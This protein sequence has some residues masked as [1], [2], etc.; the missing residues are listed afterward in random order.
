MAKILIQSAV[1][2]D[3][4]KVRGN[5]EDS[6]L[7]NG[8]FMSREAMND[9]A[10]ESKSCDEAFQ[11]YAVCDGMGGVEAGEEASYEAVSQLARY[12]DNPALPVQ[13]EDVVQLV[14]EIS[15]K[16][17]AA[18]R[19]R[20]IKSG[21]TLVL[22]LVHDGMAM[23]L[24][25]GD[26]RIYRF[27]N[28]RLT[29]V[30]VDHSEVQKL[31][32]MG[33]ITPEEAKSHPRRHAINQFLGMSRELRMLPHVESDVVLHKNDVYLLC[34][35]GLTDMVSDAGIEQ[36]LRANA[37]PRGAVQELVQAALQN[38]GRDNVTAMV[39]RV[40]EVS[41]VHRKLRGR[42][43]VKRLLTALQI[44][45]AT[46]LLVTLADYIYFLLKL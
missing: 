9:G 10:L 4:G 32:S 3:K 46:G 31:I 2:N 22:A 1:M 7:L 24:N 8:E 17:N 25:V 42:E 27:A 34:S 23:L 35:D 15:S 21:T 5:N 37:E 44:L 16:I 30:S 36:I 39:L 20:K 14:R 41:P 6:Y 12:G 45:V 29:Q 28:G 19:E 38:G 18:A 11:I 43:K 26:S 40:A 33:M 13:T